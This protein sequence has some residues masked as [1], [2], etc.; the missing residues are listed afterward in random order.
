MAFV[1]CHCRR[2]L[3]LADSIITPP[4]SVSS[5]IEG[6]KPQFPNIPVIPIVITIIVLLFIIQRK[7]TAFIGK[8]FGPVMLIWFTMI[9]V[10]GIGELSHNLS[11][12][13]ALN[14]YYAYRL[15]SEHP[16]GF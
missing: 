13:K 11:V 1:S 4:I 8:L 10:L 16:G 6:L 3:L 7:G 15:L 9:A 14:P 2:E 5:A 12:F